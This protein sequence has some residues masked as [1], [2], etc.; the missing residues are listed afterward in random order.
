MGIRDLLTERPKRGSREF[1]VSVDSL[2]FK[3]ITQVAKETNRS[4]P[5]VLAAFVDEGMRLYEEVKEHG[6][7]EELV[8]PESVT[9]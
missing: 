3:R 8:F 2:T 5:V 6:T 1:T 7:Q 9:H 4:R